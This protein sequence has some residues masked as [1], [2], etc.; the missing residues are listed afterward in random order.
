[1]FSNALTIDS[2]GTFEC[3]QAYSYEENE[4][5][6]WIHIKIKPDSIPMQQKLRRNQTGYSDNL[7]GYCVSVPITPENV[8]NSNIRNYRITASEVY[9]LTCMELNR[10]PLFTFKQAENV[11][12]NIKENNLN[13]EMFDKIKNMLKRFYEKAKLLKQARIGNEN[14]RESY[15]NRE[16]LPILGES[17][18]KYYIESTIAEFSSFVNHILN[19]Y[20]IQES[21][22][23]YGFATQVELYVNP[24]EQSKLR[25][26]NSYISSLEQSSAIFSLQMQL[27]M[28]TL[29]NRNLIENRNW[30]QICPEN[31]HGKF[32]DIVLPAFKEISRLL[33][34]LILAQN[35]DNF[36]RSRAC[37]FEIR[38]IILKDVIFPEFVYFIRKFISDL[39]PNK[40]K[41]IEWTIES[42]RQN[43]LYHKNQNNLYNFHV[44]LNFYNQ[45]LTKWREDKKGF[46]TKIFQRI[47]NLTNFQFREIH[48]ENS[49]QFAQPSRR[50]KFYPS[51]DEIKRDLINQKIVKYKQYLEYAVVAEDIKDNRGDRVFKLKFPLFLS[52][53]QVPFS[54]ALNISKLFEKFKTE[55][56]CDKYKIEIFIS[57]QKSNKNDSNSLHAKGNDFT[58]SIKVD[59]LIALRDMSDNFCIDLRIL[60]SLSRNMKTELE[61]IERENK[62]LE[63]ELTLNSK[64]NLE[65]DLDNHL[66]KKGLN[67]VVQ[68]CV[69]NIDKCGKCDKCVKN[70]NIDKCDKCDNVVRIIHEHNRYMDDDHKIYYP[71]EPEP[72]DNKRPHLQLIKFHRLFHFCIGHNTPEAEKRIFMIRNVTLSYNNGQNKFLASLKPTKWFDD[73]EFKKRENICL[74]YYKNNHKLVKDEPLVMDSEYICLFHG[75][76]NQDRSEYLNL[77]TLKIQENEKIEENR[78]ID[79]KLHDEDFER[80]ELEINEKQ[81][82]DKSKF[83]I[84]F[85]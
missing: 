78:K 22:N 33:D 82:E 62:K 11:F 85:Y 60:D 16:E 5:E 10:V 73:E 47:S 18:V 30:Y 84:E 32:I 83:I 58:R 15:L 13:N 56:E 75:T 54:R 14:L 38:K 74:S 19:Q 6:I 39:E 61:K 53:F 34:E 50:R 9:L 48:S 69:K 8:N 46:L 76:L 45:H 49:N 68:F 40:A 63:E 17:D 71:N 65:F 66:I 64:L 20:I 23:T 21:L 37:Y 24:F 42:L 67:L 81:F 72:L 44:N 7:F 43:N 2:E 12:F 59:Q 70:K 36:L 29:E 52:Y 1:M 57:D 26:L 80:F 55:G 31:N 77:E 35:K 28:F 4:N 51:K 41:D 79:F 3:E 25:E 27:K